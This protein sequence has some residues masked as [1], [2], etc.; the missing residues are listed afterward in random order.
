MTELVQ[1]VTTT[2]SKAEAKKIGRALLQQRLAACVQVI[3]PL[4]SSFWWKGKI[5]ESK[6]WY[7]IIKSRRSLYTR[8]EKAIRTLHSYEEPEI[9]C[10]PIGAV[11]LGYQQWVERETKP[12]EKRPGKTRGAEDL[13][14]T[15]VGHAGGRFLGGGDI[16]GMSNETK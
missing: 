16:G 1:I 2:K 11:S 6:E 5:S 12:K 14:N 10:L 9:I 4:E 15:E 13:I 8:I 3:G 7:C